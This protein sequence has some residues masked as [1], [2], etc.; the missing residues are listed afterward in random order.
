MTTL[1]RRQVDIMVTQSDV[2]CLCVEETRGLNVDRGWPGI[3]FTPSA[4]PPAIVPDGSI[5]AV[6]SA[7]YLA[8]HAPHTHKLHSIT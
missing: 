8:Q 5:A 3:F 7:A 6:R 2:C 4:G 1:R